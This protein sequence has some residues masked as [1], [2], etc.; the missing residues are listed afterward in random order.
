MVT[1]DFDSSK[2]ILTVNDFDEN[3]DEDDDENN[4]LVI[5]IEDDDDDLVIKQGIDVVET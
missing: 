5:A 4:S 2:T 3:D 1:K